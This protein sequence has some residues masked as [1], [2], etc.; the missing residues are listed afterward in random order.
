MACGC[1]KNRATTNINTTV[2]L[3]NVAPTQQTVSLTE[4][5]KKQINEIAE[6]INKISK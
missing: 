4:E 3:E 5:Q 6:K 2:S 1:K